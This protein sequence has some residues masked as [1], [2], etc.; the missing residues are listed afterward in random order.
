MR[1]GMARYRAKPALACII[2]ARPAGFASPAGQSLAT[3]IRAYG[4]DFGFGLYGYPAT[5]CIK[6]HTYDKCM[7][8]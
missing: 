3:I 8:L 4:R 1:S 5:A 7:H 2:G 6:A